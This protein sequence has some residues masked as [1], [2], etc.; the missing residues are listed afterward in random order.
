MLTD[1]V[2]FVVRSIRYE[3]FGRVR[4]NAKPGP[5]DTL[6]PAQKFTGQ[7][8]DDDT[9]LYYYDAQYGRFIS[10]DSMVPEPLDPQSLNRYAYGRNCKRPAN[11]VLALA[12]LSVSLA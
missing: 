7:Q 11:P 9:G 10:A 4:S 3:A 5:A 6:D 1:T 12:L 8:L 2:V